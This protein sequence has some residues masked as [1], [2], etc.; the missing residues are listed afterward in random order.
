MAPLTFPQDYLNQ[1]LSS[2]ILTGN[3]SLLA[4][5]PKPRT[6]LVISN[7]IE[8]LCEV[9]RSQEELNQREEG[10]FEGKMAVVRVAQQVGD[11]ER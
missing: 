1:L 5:N 11:E 3:Q 6:L 10:V 9:L 2:F 8:D 4:K 7:S